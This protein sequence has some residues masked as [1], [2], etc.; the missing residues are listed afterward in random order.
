ME[1]AGIKMNRMDILFV[2]VFILISLSI[3]STWFNH[4]ITFD[5]NTLKDI[6]IATIPLLLKVVNDCTSC[7]AD[8]FAKTRITE[9]EKFKASLEKS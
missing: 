9:Y 1:L 6:A 4:G 2:G 3:I 8:K 7:P 5:F